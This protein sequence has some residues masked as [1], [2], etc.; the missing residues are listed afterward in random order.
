MGEA[1]TNRPRR[2]ARERGSGGAGTHTL[3]IVLL[4]GGLLLGL[5]LVAGIVGVALW[6]GGKAMPGGPVLAGPEIEIGWPE[7]PPLAGGNY[8]PNETVILHISGIDGQDSYDAISKWLPTICDDPPHRA[9]IAT[10]SGDRMIGRLAPV[11]DPQAFAKRVTFGQVILVAGRTV[12]I[13]AHKNV[14]PPPKKK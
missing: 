5:V 2:R 3:L 12:T 14:A 9:Y 8:A 4:A 13:V 11:N 6:R 7:P 1:S 10:A